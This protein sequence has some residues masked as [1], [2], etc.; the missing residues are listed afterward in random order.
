MP[1]SLSNPTAPIPVKIQLKTELVKRELARRELLPF[2]QLINGP[3]YHA[4]WVHQDLCNMLDA[5]LEGVERKLSPRL[6]VWLPPRHGK[7]TIISKAY[8]GFILGKHPSWDIVTATYG[9]DFADDIGRNVRNTLLDPIYQDLFPELSIDPSTKAADRIDTYL[10]A[11]GGTGSLG[12]QRG[13]YKSVGIGGSLTGR[14]AHILIIDDPIKDREEADSK[15]VQE[16]NYGWYTAVGRTRIAP[17]G[18]IIVLQTRWAVED[19][20]GKILS[21]AKGN[22]EADQWGVYSFP[23]IAEKDEYDFATGK[24]LRRRVGEA[25]HPERF[26]L[27]ELIALKATLPSRDWNALYQCNPIDEA[28]GYF[29]REWF[30]SFT[31]DQE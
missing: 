30:Q 24:I 17:G 15:T 2:V 16:R 10:R 3:E 21:Q 7:T 5:F 9:Q 23:A 8:P 27:K 1:P 25:L 26:S 18:G 12:R 29:K 4:G 13:G 6:M 19:L 11:T 14:G 31:F 20:S 28:G 22:L